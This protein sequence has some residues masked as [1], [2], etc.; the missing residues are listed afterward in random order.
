M[1]KKDWEQGRGNDEYTQSVF[2]STPPQRLLTI[3]SDADKYYLAEWPSGYAFFDH[4]KERDSGDM[5]HDPYLYGSPHCSKFRSTNE[6]IPHAYVYD[7][8]Y[9]VMTHIY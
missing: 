1:E 6:F 8:Y 5:R 3:E 7:V 9:C 2:H 4:N